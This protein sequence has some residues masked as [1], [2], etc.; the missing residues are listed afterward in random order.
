MAWAATYPAT[1]A[2][3]ST[4]TATIRPAVPSAYQCFGRLAA[5]PESPLGL[6]PLGRRTRARRRAATQNTH[7]GDRREIT[8]Q[9][10]TA[11]IRPAETQLVDQALQVD[12]AA[13]VGDA[14]DQ[15]DD[16]HRLL[17]AAVVVAGL[18]AVDA[19]DPVPLHQRVLRVPQ[20]GHQGDQRQADVEADD[21]QR[22]CHAT[23][24]TGT[25]ARWALRC[26]GSP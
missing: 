11:R 23:A 19:H 17:D 22:E 2:I 8:E 20:P 13:D 9:A 12:V 18:A 10:D 15:P 26:A 3:G 6:P 24:P 1:P 7:A 25:D 21:D 4:M 14:G 5:A 16:Q